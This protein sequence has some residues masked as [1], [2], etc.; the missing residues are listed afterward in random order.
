MKNLNLLSL[1]IV[2]ALLLGVQPATAVV[3]V[4][5]NTETT[6]ATIS[7]KELKK[8]HR[9]EKLMDKIQKKMDKM[10]AKGLD[11]N[12]PVGKWLWLAIILAVASLVASIL[13]YSSW[14]VVGLWWLPSLL[15]T[16]AGICFLIWL[17]K[18]LQVI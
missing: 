13:F 5:T 9:I 14:L 17:L 11:R 7:K 6:T 1:L 18:Y 8:Q 15:W 3:S 4:Q 2:V 10:E 16:A 12:D